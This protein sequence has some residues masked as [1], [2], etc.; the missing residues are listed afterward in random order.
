[1]DALVD[2]T[3]NAFFKAVDYTFTGKMS[4]IKLIVAVATVIVTIS[5]VAAVGSPKQVELTAGILLHL[6]IFWLGFLM[7]LGGNVQLSRNFVALGTTFVVSTC[8]CFVR[9]Y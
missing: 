7:V 3:M 8:V 5:L 2:S 1:M 6:S 9:M 4:W